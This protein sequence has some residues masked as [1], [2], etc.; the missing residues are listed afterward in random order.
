MNLKKETEDNSL[1]TLK[2]C[3]VKRGSV[4][5]IMQVPEKFTPTELPE[6]TEAQMQMFI[7]NLAMI[8]RDELFTSLQFL[9]FFSAILGRINFISKHEAKQS[10]HRTPVFSRVLEMVTEDKDYLEN[11][12]AACPWLEQDSV[13][14]AF[15]AKPENFMML[16]WV[17]PDPCSVEQAIAIAIEWKDK[18]QEIAKEHPALLQAIENM[19][20]GRVIRPRGQ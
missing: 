6:V 4:M 14:L 5:W 15:L 1:K 9:L 13:V 2:E 12:V 7:E 17:V 8:I 20:T 16:P 18:M 19:I 3:G 10:H 11:L